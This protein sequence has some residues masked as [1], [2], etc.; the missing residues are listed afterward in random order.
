MNNFA[1]EYA[2]LIVLQNRG[3]KGRG[4]EGRGGEGR[5][6]ANHRRHVLTRKIDLAIRFGLASAIS[7]T[8]DSEPEASRSRL[9]TKRKSAHQKLFIKLT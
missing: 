7:K 2:V 8:R 6:G 3:G 4:G 1:T 5:G 9:R